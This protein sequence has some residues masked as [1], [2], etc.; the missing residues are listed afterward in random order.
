MSFIQTFLRFVVITAVLGGSAP[1]LAQSV[2]YALKSYLTENRSKWSLSEADIQAWSIS[3]QYSD[4]STGL[5]YAY[6]QQELNG[7]PIFNA[8]SSTALRDGKV[9]H[10]ASRMVPKAASKANAADPRIS[11]SAAVVFAA[12]HLGLSLTEQPVGTYREGDRWTWHFSPCGIAEQEIR[13]HLT[14]VQVGDRLRLA[15]NVNL[16]LLKGDDWWN[17]RVDAET[18]QFLEKNNWT[19][20]CQFDHPAGTSCS[21]Q[22]RISA[23][24][25]VR[26][27]APAVSNVPVYGV[28]EL[29]LEAPSF[30]PRTVVAE[31]NSADASPFGW[32][33]VDGQVGVEYK[34]TRGNNV[35]AYEDRDD[36]NQPGY[37]PSGGDSLNFNFPMDL[38]NDALTNED[39]IIA[40]LFYTNNMIHNILY[41]HGF[42][43]EAGNFQENN[44]GRGGED[45]DYVRA[46][47]QDGSG[48]NN[49]N[50]STPD[51][52]NRPRMQ[53]YLWDN[54]VTSGLKV[55]SP[56]SI[57][58]VYTAAA[59]TFG[60]G[61]GNGVTGSVVLVQDSVD[62]STDGC[63]ALLNTADLAGKIALID[64]SSCP[65]SDQVKAANNAGAI[66]VVVV[67]NLTTPPSA[68]G[69]NS[70]GIAIPSVMVGK[71]TG[72]SIKARLAAGEEVEVSMR[73]NP[74][75]DSALDNGVIAH[76]YGHGL[77]NRLT[78][79]PSA[80]GCLSNRE[81]GGEGWS[82]W[83]ALIL[84]IE[85][86]DTGVDARGIGTYLLGENTSG[87]GIR[88]FRYSTNMIINPQV[89]G[90]VST[91]GVPHPIG[92]IWCQSIWDLTWKLIETEGFDPDWYY[93]NG[94]NNT[95]MRLVIE[96]MKLQPCRPGYIDARDAIL[97][98]DALLYNNAHQCLIWE[99]FTRR[100]Y[101]KGADQGS[102]D[103]TNDQ[104]ESYTLPN[105]CLIP[106][107]PP[108]AKFA[109]SDTSS[110]RGVFQFRDL[111]TDIPQYY[112]WNFGDGSTSTEEN[113]WHTYQSPGI[114]TVVLVVSNTLG[115]STHTL[116]VEYT[117]DPAPTVSGDAVV[118]AG[119]SS[120]LTASVQSGYS[121]AWYQNG[122]L[123][124]E[125]TT[126]TSDNLLGTTVFE[127]KQFAEGPQ[128]RVGAADNTI[129]GG[130]YQ[131]GGQGRLLFEA[132]AP[133]RLL[134]AVVYAQNAGNRTFNLY[135]NTNAI[136]Q[137]V[138]VEVSEGQHR[139]ALNFD[140]PAA[141][142][143]A[144]GGAGQKLYRNV[145][146]AD[147][148]YTIDSLV[149]I[150]SSN[151]SASPTSAYFYLYDWEVRYCYSE[152]T[153]FQVEV[154]PG[155]VAAFT[156][157]T[158]NGLNIAFENTTTGTATSYSW[159]FGDGTSV[160]NVQNPLHTYLTPGLYTVKLMVSDG[161]CSS[162]YELVVP[163]GVSAQEEPVEL[164]GLRIYP[165]PAT[166]QFF[167]ELGSQPVT[168]LQ[169][170][171]Q[172]AAGRTLRQQVS[173][174]KRTRIEVEGLPA[175]V[176]Q[177][178]V[179]S[180]AG[181]VNRKI[182]LVN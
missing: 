140:I 4:R 105:I 43:E 3:D 127:V 112:Q 7:L 102:N 144:V 143:Y 135:D 167:L 29:P 110:C 58:G 178:R 94:G 53:M 100:G 154:T 170:E 62:I 90:D 161:T 141:G 103:E 180:P 132:H 35:H 2:N 125:G 64:R 142:L 37:S 78:G 61:L 55:I 87:E 46:E 99:V 97:A 165:N 19:V 85:P 51:D 80:S 22:E 6:I 34:I 9:V 81:Q 158:V 10:F 131:S 54:P 177:L 164:A 18:G 49:A 138:T 162:E 101:G 88:R 89:Y 121:A 20:F 59:A 126:F 119:N 111:S 159:D 11:A 113:P 41:H 76:E 68:M 115:E 95:A 5:T 123:K 86:D 145:T 175:G 26:V 12:Q 128:A 173:S 160:A 52:G 129:G 39:G 28:F 70:E 149:S 109:V 13:A 74:K 65:F 38:T 45:G 168:D 153:L 79:G 156:A 15:W 60:P 69:G 63:E 136:I 1:L 72:D 67:N 120:T 151:F 130:G 82:D 174:Q 182:T 47:A 36:D 139:V 171:L 146:G 21:S 48:S 133:F 150:Y 98:A 114:Y 134:S 40:N 152:P 17:V 122:A 77:S 172:D 42:T 23:V 57:A 66:G 124:G 157:S 179:K 106:T 50:F 16:P 75:Y 104:V 93:G 25:E 107:A 155:P 27:A 30:G 116:T 14:Y 31:P 147:Y 92:E 91:S 84:S 96:G 24:R 148:P 32:L 44:Y 71:I 8:I 181:V 83:L 169:L 33:D 117:V 108:S 163:V 118:C 137:T 56:S 166:D 176:Y 73:K